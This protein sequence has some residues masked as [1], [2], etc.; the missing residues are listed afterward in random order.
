MDKDIQSQQ[1]RHQKYIWNLF[2]VNKNAGKRYERMLEGI[3]WQKKFLL[4]VVCKIREK[5]VDN[6]LVRRMVIYVAFVEF[7]VWFQ[8]FS[9]NWRSFDSC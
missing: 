2:A 1:Y 6:R 9:I 3:L 8:V 7:L 4:F 5:P